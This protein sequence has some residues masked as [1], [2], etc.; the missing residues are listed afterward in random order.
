MDK[1]IEILKRLI[2]IKFTG[3]IVIHFNQ[4]GIRSVR[5]VNEENI[6]LN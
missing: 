2:S 4:G 6:T 3:S 5:K 1:L